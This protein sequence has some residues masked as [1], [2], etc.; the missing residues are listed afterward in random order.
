MRRAFAAAIAVLALTSC[1]KETPEDLIPELTPIERLQAHPDQRLFS[2]L[3]VKDGWDNQLQNATAN[4]LFA[5]GNAAILQYLSDR[6]ISRTEAMSADET[7]QLIALHQIAAPYT[8]DA[9]PM[10]YVQSRCEHTIGTQRH[11]ITLF[12]QRANRQTTIQNARLNQPDLVEGRSIHSID[13]VIALP[14]VFDHLSVNPD[15]SAFLSALKRSDFSAN[16][17]SIFKKSG[18]ITVFAP[19][20]FAFASFMLEK[21]Y[22]TLDQMPQAD[23]NKMVRAHIVEQSNLRANDLKNKLIKTAGGQVTIAVDGNTL[24]VSDLSGRKAKMTQADVQSTN[25]VV[26]LIDRVMLP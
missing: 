18:A 13:Q 8:A 19:T 24:L 16:N 12:I 23:L 2:E 14:T 5:P 25:G 22:R 3:L 11:P 21:G 1:Q 4:T 26:H 15:C 7:R 10:G 9:L 20:N 6:G 17:F